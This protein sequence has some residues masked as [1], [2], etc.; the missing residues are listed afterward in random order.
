MCFLG[1]SLLVKRPLHVKPLVEV[2]HLL[3]QSLRLRRP[4]AF[5]HQRGHVLQA[6]VLVHAN[7]VRLPVAVRRPQTLMLR[8]KLESQYA[9]EESSRGPHAAAE[10]ILAT[11][12]PV[13]AA[14]TLRA[15]A[16]SQKP[17]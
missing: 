16:H 7:Y 4:Q 9:A 11:P 2:F 5:L 10:K 1:V 3:D 6:A 8:A 12:G 13:V 15:H 17:S 14:R